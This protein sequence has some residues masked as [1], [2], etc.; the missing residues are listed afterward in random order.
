MDSVFSGSNQ[1]LFQVPCEV[2]WAILKLVINTDLTLFVQCLTD[3]NSLTQKGY[4]TTFWKEWGGRT[5][6][7]EAPSSL[8]PQ[9]PPH[10]TC[11]ENYQRKWHSSHIRPLCSG[12][13]WRKQRLHR[14]HEQVHTEETQ[15]PGPCAGEQQQALC[16]AV[17]QKEREP[18]AELEPLLTKRVPSREGT[19]QPAEQS[20]L[21]YL[22]SVPRATANHEACRRLM[23]SWEN[24][25]LSEHHITQLNKTEWKGR[26]DNYLQTTDGHSY[27][28]R[29]RNYIQ[30]KRDH[31]TCPPHVGMALPRFT[32]L[33][34]KLS[35]SCCYSKQAFFKAKL[36]QT[37]PMKGIEK[38]V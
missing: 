17:H 9:N 5:S 16:M 30:G 20:Q 29:H 2:A 11:D 8:P 21:Q 35:T 23:R 26:H 12:D 14:H 13:R 27:Q 18:H 15:I 19:S 10:T 32:F 1:C 6:G 31:S 36:E 24:H 33:L 38:I 3:Y 37:Y 25:K 34:P 22:V 4:K 7:Q 28:Q